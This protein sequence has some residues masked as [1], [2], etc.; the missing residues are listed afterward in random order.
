MTAMT[1]DTTMQRVSLNMTSLRTLKSV[2]VSCPRDMRA[3]AVITRGTL[4]LEVD[5]E[6]FCAATDEKSAAAPSVA[7]SKE[8]ATP[9]RRLAR[10]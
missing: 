6:D 4:R 1:A 2:H 10:N 5:G 7:C 8:Q 3:E 9:D